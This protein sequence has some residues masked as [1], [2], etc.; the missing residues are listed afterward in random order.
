MNLVISRCGQIRCLYDETI[1]LAELGSL[2]ITRA[3]SVEPDE[4][5]QW[6][7]NLGCVE[8][9]LL[10]PFTVRSQALAAERGWLEAHWLW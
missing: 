2:S 1:D 10:G 4:H 9:P 6:W 3:S 7:A 8:G 5:G